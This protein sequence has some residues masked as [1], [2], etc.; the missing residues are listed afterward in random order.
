MVQKLSKN[1][2]NLLAYWPSLD[3]GLEVFLVQNDLF[4]LEE[5]QKAFAKV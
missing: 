5:L 1:K 4:H 2:M 3:T